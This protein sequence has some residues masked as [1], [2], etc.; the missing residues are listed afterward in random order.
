M[1]NL[2]VIWRT[3]HLGSIQ[4]CYLELKNRLKQ[5]AMA[6]CFFLPSRQ[7]EPGSFEFG[8]CTQE[9]PDIYEK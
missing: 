4:S 7:N 6:A 1:L 2:S 9:Q 5:A 8:S 3:G